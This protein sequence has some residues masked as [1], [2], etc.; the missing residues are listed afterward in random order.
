MTHRTV[1]T[2]DATI[3]CALRHVNDFLARAAAIDPT[4][5]DPGDREALFNECVV[6]ARLLGRIRALVERPKLTDA[7]Q[8]VVVRR[9]S[10]MAVQRRLSYR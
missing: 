2:A 10:E 7:D 4:G 5:L 8:A 1:R 9:L 6:V 3:A